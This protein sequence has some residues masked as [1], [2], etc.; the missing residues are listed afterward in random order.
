MYNIILFAK[1]GGLVM[2]QLEALKCAKMDLIKILISM[3][4]L[5]NQIHFHQKF[6]YLIIHTVFTFVIIVDIWN[7]VQN[8]ANIQI[9]KIL[10]D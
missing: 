4:K 8:T 5:I 2:S 10:L 7:L 1:K 6:K 3:E 9:F